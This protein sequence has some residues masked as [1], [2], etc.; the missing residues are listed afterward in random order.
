MGLKRIKNA[1]LMIEMLLCD[2]SMCLV[3]VGTWV[4]SPVLTLYPLHTY[5][6][7]DRQTDRHMRERKRTREKRKKEGA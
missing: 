5:I 4:Q 1:E 6:Q 7:T 3:C 2:K